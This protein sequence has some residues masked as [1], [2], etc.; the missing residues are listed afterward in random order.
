MAS[1]RKQYKVDNCEYGVVGRIPICH[2]D[3]SNKGNVVAKEEEL[4]FS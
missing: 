4:F 2:S 1:S 3:S